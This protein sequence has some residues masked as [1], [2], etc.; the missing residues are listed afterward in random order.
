VKSSKQF[1]ND[2][3]K[4][5]FEGL[6][7]KSTYDF[8]TNIEGKEVSDLRINTPSTT[9]ILNRA[10]IVSSF[11][12]DWEDFY[13]YG[14]FYKN[15]IEIN[16]ELVD[17][18]VYDVP[19]F[20]PSIFTRKVWDAIHEGAGFTYDWDSIDEDDIRFNE[21]ILPFN[22]QYTV[23]AQEKEQYTVELGTDLSPDPD[24]SSPAEE[25]MNEVEYATASGFSGGSYIRADNPLGSVVTQK[26]SNE[27]PVTAP[28]LLPDSAFT[29]AMTILSSVL[30]DD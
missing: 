17:A 13:V 9:H 22:S 8:F 11:D 14:T 23:S 29:P 21:T 28:I 18:N 26:N 30:K 15:Q 4:V 19:D 12:H 10:N 16:N 25:D 24:D 1:N 20:K 3:N 2:T 5:H 27:P 6:V 7:F